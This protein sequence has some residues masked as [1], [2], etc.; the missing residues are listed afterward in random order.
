MKLA[1]EILEVAEKK[2]QLSSMKSSADL[3]IQY[4]KYW[5]KDGNESLAVYRGLKSLKYSLGVFSDTYKRLC[6]KAKDNGFSEYIPS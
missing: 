3:N 5:I 2:A 4:C 6:K 1:N